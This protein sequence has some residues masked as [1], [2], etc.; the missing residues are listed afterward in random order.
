VSNARERLAGQAVLLLPL[1]L[2]GVSMQALAQSASPL[3]PA[4]SGVASASAAPLKTT[5]APPADS[6]E[7]IRI[8]YQAPNGCPDA[9]AFLQGVL[10]RT[11]R[12]RAAAPHELARVFQVKVVSRRGESL[13]EISVQRHS[14]AKPVRLSAVGK[15][16]NVLNTLAQFAA[17]SLD[18]A[19]A[20]AS[21]QELEL[22]ANPYRNWTGPVAPP[23]PE[24]PYRNW[25]EAV[26]PSL[27]EN[28]YRKPS[29]AMTRE[30]PYNPYRSERPASAELPENPYRSR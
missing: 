15:C 25:G 26:S 11:P 8:Q 20:L 4:R 1:V 14:D 18:P 19:A 17:I 9:L 27:P 13:G 21:A 16:E 29:A 24:N 23:L 2:T 6:K 30:L 12:A 28:P 3:S 5:L 10:G 7:P 22:P